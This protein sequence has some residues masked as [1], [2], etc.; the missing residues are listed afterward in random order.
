M[1]QI[2]LESNMD[3]LM[4]ISASEYYFTFTNQSY[5]FSYWY[6]RFKKLIGSLKGWVA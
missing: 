2:D 3:R 4:N 6:F 5:Y 1:N